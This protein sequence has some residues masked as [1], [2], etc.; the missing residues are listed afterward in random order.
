MVRIVIGERPVLFNEACIG[1]FTPHFTLSLAPP[2]E[3]LEFFM[4]G[5]G[6]IFITQ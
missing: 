6:N 2:F 3:V 1:I 5:T 4:N